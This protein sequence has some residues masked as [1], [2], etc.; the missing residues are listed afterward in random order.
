MNDL[1]Q[2]F[3]HP[4]TLKLIK[5]LFGLAV[6][7]FLLAL[8]NRGLSR[9]VTSNSTRYAARKFL[10]FVTFILFFFFVLNTLGYQLSNLSIALGVAGAGITFALQEVIVS[11]AG[12][13]AVLFGNFYKV[14]DR[15]QLGGIKGDVVDI[16]VLRTTVME[17]GDWVAGD[18]YN[19]KMVR[20]ANSFVFKEPVY[21]YSGDFPFLWDEIKVPIRHGA[22]IAYAKDLFQKILN[23]N[24]GSYA[25][26]CKKSWEKLT[27]E[28]YV[29]DARI[30][31]MVS[32][33][34]DENWITFT[35]RY[36]VDFKRRRATKDLLFS[37][38]LKAIEANPKKLK[39]ATTAFE[40]KQV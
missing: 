20:V 38:I 27:K 36:V 7:Y 21:N 26:E 10:G 3:Q 37:E 33:I 6:M 23:E 35:L 29:E 5:I 19:G 16:G 24:L 31:P 28:L 13:L 1:M 14:G 2:L 17:M 30:E 40:V 4:L 39:I 18:L 34:F 22:D 25:Q 9:Y 15:V 32:M 8:T 11:I 12:F